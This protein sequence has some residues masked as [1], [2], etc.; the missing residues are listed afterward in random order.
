MLNS[1]VHY[2]LKH[3]NLTSSSNLFNLVIR[4]CSFMKMIHSY[5]LYCYRIR[6]AI[7]TIWGEKE[8]Q[9]GEKLRNHVL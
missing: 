8:N 9:D 2:R 4:K 5:F 6:A 1:N 3:E 7:G